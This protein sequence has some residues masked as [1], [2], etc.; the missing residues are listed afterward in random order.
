MAGDFIFQ[1]ALESKPAQ[2]LGDPDAPH[3]FTHIDDFA[4][5]LITLSESDLAWGQ[6][7]HV[8]TLS[9]V[10]AR[11]FA[12]EVARQAGTETKV[13]VPPKPI[14]RFLGLFNAPLRETFE[15]EYERNEPF[16]VD[17]SKFERTFNRNAIPL[18]DGIANTLK[19]YRG[20]VT[21][22]GEQA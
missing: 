2:W 3:S 5:A 15:M 21:G 14:L 1:K 8:P 9:D 19:W 4:S 11:Q 17:S 7:W 20:N 12:S 18:R 6:V 13:T 22:S 10:T 16:L